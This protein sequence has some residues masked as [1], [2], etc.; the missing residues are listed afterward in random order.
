MKAAFRFLGVSLITIIVAGALWVGCTSKSGGANCKK[1]DQS[2]SSDS[3]CC[4]TPQKLYCRYMGS[5]PG[6]GYQCQDY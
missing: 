1:I 6:G 2:C 3:D 4:Q 5:G